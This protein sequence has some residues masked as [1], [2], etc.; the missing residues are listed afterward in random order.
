MINPL[1]TGAYIARLRKKRDWTQVEL[2]DKL[3]VT[4]QAVTG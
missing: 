4:H 1:K 3:H 2:A